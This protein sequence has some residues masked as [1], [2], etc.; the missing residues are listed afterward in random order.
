MSKPCIA[1]TLGDPA[2]VG[3]ETIVAAWKTG[4]YLSVSARQ[5]LQCCE[6]TARALRP[7]EAKSKRS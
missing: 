3:P 1:I 4:R 7:A 5:F 6:T 2:G